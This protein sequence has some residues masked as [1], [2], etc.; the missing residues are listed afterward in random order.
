MFD[1][2]TDMT[3]KAGQLQNL[4]AAAVKDPTERK[5]ATV[6]VDSSPQRP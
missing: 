4:L 5:A 2:T 1:E 3:E 6:K